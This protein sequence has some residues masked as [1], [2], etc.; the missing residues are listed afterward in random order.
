MSNDRRSEQGPPIQRVLDLLTTAVDDVSAAIVF[1]NA[2]PGA[3]TASLPDSR[4]QG[5][6]TA[7][8]TRPSLQVALNNLGQAIDG[9]ARV[10]GSD[11]GGLRDKIRSDIVAAAA[12]VIDADRR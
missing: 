2:H 7:Q 4:S 6:F 1:V 8:L 9:L 3:A 10:S 11:L 5:A 12:A